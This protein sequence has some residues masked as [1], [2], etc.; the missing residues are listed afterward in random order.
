MWPII[1]FLFHPIYIVV[2]AMV[3][4]RLGETDLAGFGLGSL[5]CGIMALSICICFSFSC[6]TVVA[7]AYGAK[8]YRMCRVYLN[9]QYFLNTCLFP[10]VLLPLIF[11]RD[12]Y[13]AI[14]Q[15]PE[16]SDKAALYVWTSLPGIYFY[17]Q[18]F[19]MT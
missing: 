13:A 8:D 2:N 5:T 11:I 6:G 18:A 19:S 4:G 16:V 1:G 15:N 7:I 14:G 9:R 3:C 10:F 17:V 12:I